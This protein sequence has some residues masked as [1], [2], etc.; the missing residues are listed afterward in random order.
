M[1]IAPDSFLGIILASDKTPLTIGTGNREMH[2]VLLSIA[3]I[4]AGIRM[5]ATSHTFA[6]IG[7][8]PIP[9]FPDE[10]SANIKAALGARVYHHCLSLITE[11]LR[12]AE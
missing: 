11:R 5:K 4:K 3:N 9:K 10:Y 8:L 12:Q 6:L 2:P 7:Y 1:R